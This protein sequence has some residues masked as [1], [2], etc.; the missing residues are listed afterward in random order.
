MKK[1][2]CTVLKTKSIPHF[3][4][5]VGGGGGWGVVGG[6][7][8]KNGLY[9]VLDKISQILKLLLVLNIITKMIYT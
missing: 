7:V 6:W 3:W 5:V 1:R 8:G 2:T 9:L 4:V